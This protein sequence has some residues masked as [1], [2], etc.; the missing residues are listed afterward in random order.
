MAIALDELD[1]A[2]PD[3]ASIPRATDACDATCQHTMARVKML[4]PI[5]FGYNCEAGHDQRVLFLANS[6]RLV[7]GFDGRQMDIRCT[8]FGGWRPADTGTLDIERNGWFADFPHPTTKPRTLRVRCANNSPKYCN[9]AYDACSTAV[10][11]RRPIRRRAFYREAE[12][13]S[14]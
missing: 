9:P 14:S 10:P 4:G 1:V 6:W 3:R 11:R 13:R 12:R 8:D 5:K 7:F 2:E